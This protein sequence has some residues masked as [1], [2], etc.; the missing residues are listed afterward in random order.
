MGLRSGAHLEAIEDTPVR[1]A[2]GPDHGGQMRHCRVGANHE[3]PAALRLVGRTESA[4]LDEAT[5]CAANDARRPGSRQDEL[6]NGRSDGLARC[7]AWRA[8]GG[9]GLSLTGR[10]FGPVPFRLLFEMRRSNAHFPC[11]LGANL[12]NGCEP[13]LGL[14]LDP[15]LRR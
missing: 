5:G 10:L 11:R 2:C 9:C 15:N 8:R 14:W 13:D 6:L 3:P 1:V 12:R 4:D 7:V